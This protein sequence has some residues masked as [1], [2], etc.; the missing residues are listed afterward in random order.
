[1][2]TDKLLGGIGPS[3]A[4][5]R[6][7]ALLHEILDS[8]I[9]QVGPSL[10]SQPSVELTVRNTIAGALSDLG[11]GLA[12]IAQLRKIYDSTAANPALHDHPERLRAAILMAQIHIERYELDEAQKLVN[13][14]TEGYHRR[15]EEE[16]DGAYDARLAQAGIELHSGK[17]DLAQ[18][19]FGEI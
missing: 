9:D 19:H 17:S 15:G 18:K 16:S 1:G 8:S 4:R 14:A 13:D 12:A 11:D 6:D 5:G 7:T 3:V 2:F 10:S